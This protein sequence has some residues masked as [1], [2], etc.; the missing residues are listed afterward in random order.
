MKTDR[1]LT[2]MI[3]V[4]SLSIICAVAQDAD[5]IF[6]S[7]P[8]NN[9]TNTFTIGEAGDWEGE[10]HNLTRGY[11]QDLEWFPML[12]LKYDSVTGV[13]GAGCLCFSAESLFG[14]HSDNEIRMCNHEFLILQVE[15]GEGGGKL[16]LGYGAWQMTGCAT[17]LSILRT[18]G[19]TMEVEPGETYLGGEFQLNL[20]LLNVAVGLYTEIDGD[21]EDETLVTWSTGIGF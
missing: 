19:D 10:P 14:N 12:G 3:I 18:W 11:S 13:T 9:L 15:A 7:E 4:M 2:A 8:T 17:K 6:F 1:L 5:E 16:Q 20:L 21:G